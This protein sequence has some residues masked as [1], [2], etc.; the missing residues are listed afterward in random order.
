MEKSLADFTGDFLVA[1]V[2]PK[3]FEG[4]MIPLSRER[5]DKLHWSLA[6]RAT[7]SIGHGR[8]YT[9]SQGR[10]IKAIKLTAN[11]VSRTCVSFFTARIAKMACP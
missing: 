9:Q 1:L 11:A 2:A 10:H 4:R 6:L 5:F 8:H 3:F 7:W